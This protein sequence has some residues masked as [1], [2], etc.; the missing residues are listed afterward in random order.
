MLKIIRDK[1]FGK[2]SSMAEEK[3]QQ[4]E[5]DWERL[6]PEFAK[7]LQYKGNF[8]KCAAI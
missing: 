8:R 6:D 1:I 5:P 2:K 3:Q 4:E 7:C